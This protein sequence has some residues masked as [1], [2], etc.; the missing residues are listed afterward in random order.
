M[1]ASTFAEHY[2]YRVEW[3]EQTLGAKRGITFIY[4]SICKLSMG[5][6]LKKN[7]YNPTNICTMFI[8]SL[9]DFISY[10]HN[11]S[12]GWKIWVNMVMFCIVFLYLFS[13]L[14]EISV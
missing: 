12:N 7:T 10:M 2:G 4:V 5:L 13:F 8:S 3:V 1:G 14:G 6:N 11:W 9:N